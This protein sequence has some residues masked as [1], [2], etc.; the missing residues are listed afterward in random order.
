VEEPKIASIQLVI[1][2]ED[3]PIVLDLAHE[4]LDKVTLSVKVCII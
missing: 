3:S 2:G 4:T 1:P